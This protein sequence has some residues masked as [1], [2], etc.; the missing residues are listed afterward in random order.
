MSTLLDQYRQMASQARLDAATAALPNVRQVHL[1]SA[2]RLDQ[3][4]HRLESVAQAKARNDAAKSTSPSRTQD[5][6]RP[7]RFH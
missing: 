6:Q 4:I 3:I 1:T 2:D 5:T 7:S